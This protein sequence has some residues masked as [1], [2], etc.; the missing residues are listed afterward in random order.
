M[1]TILDA[2]WTLARPILHALDPERA[3]DV[4]L[5]M[6]KSMHAPSGPSG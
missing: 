5:A 2:G 6:L 4:T 1:S 3:H